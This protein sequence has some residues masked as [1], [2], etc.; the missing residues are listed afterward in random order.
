MAGVVGPATVPDAAAKAALPGSVNRAKPD[1]GK[2]RDAARLGVIESTDPLGPSAV[3]QHPKSLQARLPGL[4]RSAGLTG[5]RIEV[6]GETAA[7]GEAV[8]STTASLGELAL[9]MLAI[10]FV[11]L[12]LFL[13]ALLAPLY[14]L[15]A[16]V[17]SLLQRSASRSG[18]SRTASA[19]TASCTTC[20]SRSPCC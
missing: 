6:G 8:S 3:G 10:T 1:A 11:L 5:V 7:V 14:L 19:M 12:A 16:S 15:A 2:V 13:R 17:L 18:S 9:I 20:R 4:V